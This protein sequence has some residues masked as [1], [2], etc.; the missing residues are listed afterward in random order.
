MSTFSEILRDLAGLIFPAQ[1]AICH[2][3]LVKGESVFCTCCRFQ[4][5]LTGFCNEADN[6]MVRRFDGLLPVERAAALMWFIDG[7]HWQRIIHRFKYKEEWFLALKMG[8]W[9]GAVLRDSGLYND[10]DVVV[11][12]P[13]HII[14]RLRRNYNQSEIIA[15]AIARAIGAKLDIRSVKRTVNNPSQTRSSAAERWSNAE[16]IFALRRPE[17]LKG[18]HILLVDDVFTTG[19]TIVSCG[20]TI[21]KGA[22]DVR[23]SVATLAI[24]QRA[25]A[26]DR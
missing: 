21:L 20:E 3:D 17:A 1:C 24:S 22:E 6:P 8:Q 15:Y 23:L 25:M 5:P 12:I 14:K 11:P 9:L 26:I 19:S 13:L 2:R 18:K 10:I 16:G 4:A 7:S